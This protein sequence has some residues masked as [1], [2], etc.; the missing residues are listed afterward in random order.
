MLLPSHGGDSRG[1]VGICRIG[2]G[3]ALELRGSVTPG[4]EGMRGGR[5]SCGLGLGLADTILPQAMSGR[6][7]AIAIDVVDE[8]D[9]IMMEDE[10]D[11]CETV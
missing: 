6:M 2:S 8:G 10:L 1:G 11:G 7:Y 9:W 5:D 4:M 3:G